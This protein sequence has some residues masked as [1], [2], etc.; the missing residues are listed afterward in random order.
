MTVPRSTL[1]GVIDSNVS[2]TPIFITLAAA[3]Q[4][5]D[6]SRYELFDELDVQNVILLDGDTYI[7]GDLNQ[8]WAEATLEALGE[9]TNME[10]T[11]I[12]VN[13]NLTVAG[14]IKPS[15]DYFPHLLVIG[16]VQCDALQIKYN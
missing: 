3:K 13:G 2:A 14:T 12:L 10:D 11:L 4:Q 8:Q 15:H 1:A 9:D 16:N 7:K 5:L 6:L